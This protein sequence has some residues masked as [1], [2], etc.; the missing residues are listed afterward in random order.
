MRT[1]K[2]IK[3]LEDFNGIN[4]HAKAQVL[5]TAYGYKPATFIYLEAMPYTKEDTP[6]R[7]SKDTYTLLCLILTNLGLVF[8]NR[9]RMISDDESKTVHLI[10]FCI[11][12]DSQ[13]AT[14]LHGAIVSNNDRL[15]GITLG[16]PLTAAEAYASDNMLPIHNH[17]LSTK[18]VNERNMR[19]LNHRLSKES[20]EDEVKY[21]QIHGDALKDLS[22]T[23]YDHVTAE[24]E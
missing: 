3:A 21:L 18:D 20:W 23:I 7:V 24:N 19:M 4:W 22:R 9:D 13:T 1:S 2:A 15:T 10:D 16:Y 17:P 8:E 6:I 11:S 5:L 14:T 12:R